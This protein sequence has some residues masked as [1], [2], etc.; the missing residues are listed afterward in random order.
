[1]D[2]FSLHLAH[3]LSLIE[4]EISEQANSALGSELR[5]VCCFIYVLSIAPATTSCFSEKP[6]MFIFMPLDGSS[7]ERLKLGCTA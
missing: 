4:F 1:M 6:A 2:H 3:L 7:N 5:L